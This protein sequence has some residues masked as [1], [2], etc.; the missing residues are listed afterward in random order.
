MHVSTIELPITEIGAAFVSRVMSSYSGFRCHRT[1][2]LRDGEGLSGGRLE[3]RIRTTQESGRRE[4]DDDSSIFD[5]IA[6][7]GDWIKPHR[8]L[9]YVADNEGSEPNAVRSG[10]R[11]PHWTMPIRP[12]RRQLYESAVSSGSSKLPHLRCAR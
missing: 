12:V 10:L 7:G 6:F 11:L 4:P 2:C 9:V 8:L 3:R 1:C 5:A